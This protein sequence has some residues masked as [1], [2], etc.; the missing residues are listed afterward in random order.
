M[1][2]F[3]RILTFFVHFIIQFAHD[4][5]RQKRRE[6]VQRVHHFRM[7]FGDFRTQ[8]RRRVVRREV[9]PIVFQHFQIKFLQKAVGHKR[10]DRLD[11]I[12]V[13]G[14]VTRGAVDAERVGE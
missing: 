1:G 9:M 8:K 12:V 13:N 4:F 6:L 14:D 5:V 2:H 10:V 7:L 3:F 11:F